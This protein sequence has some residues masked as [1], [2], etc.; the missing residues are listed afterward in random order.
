MLATPLHA[1]IRVKK[2]MDGLHRRVS[3]LDFRVIILRKPCRLK[4]A[5]THDALARMTNRVQAKIFFLLALCAPQVGLFYFSGSDICLSFRSARQA[6]MVDPRMN[7]FIAQVFSLNRPSPQT[8]LLDGL[9]ESP[10]ARRRFYYAADG[11]LNEES[12]AAESLQL[13]NPFISRAHLLFGA[14]IYAC[15]SDP[16]DKL[17]WLILE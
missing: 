7:L 15:R 1:S 5:H 6:Q 2:L 17:R 3:A 16:H 8:I 9:T 14:R 12:T 13:V 10:S 4:P 11:H